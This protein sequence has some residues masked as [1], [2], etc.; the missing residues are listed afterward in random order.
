VAEL[1]LD[2]VERRAVAGEL[3]GV[4]QLVRREAAADPNA[5]SSRRN[6]TRTF[7][8]DHGRPRSG[9]R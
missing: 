7:A 4:A 9:R 2:R 1:A 5:G 8:L 3:D 6:S